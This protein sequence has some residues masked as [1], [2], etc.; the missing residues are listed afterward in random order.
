MVFI[1]FHESQHPT[2]TKSLLGTNTIGAPDQILPDAYSNTVSK[3]VDRVGAGVAAVHL[4]RS[5]G[6]RNG[7]RK[8][9]GGGSEFLFA[10]DA[11]LLTNSHVV[12]AGQKH[13]DHKHN[14]FFSPRS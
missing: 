12:R 1:V 13:R 7:E 4:W 5:T 9:E 14:L 10:P 3:V 11:H 8:R 2:P 6:D